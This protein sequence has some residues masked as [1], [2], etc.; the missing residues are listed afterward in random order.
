[1]APGRDRTVRPVSAEITSK[2]ALAVVPPES[3]RL[4][5]RLG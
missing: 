5:F 1:M 3:A 4:A 2:R